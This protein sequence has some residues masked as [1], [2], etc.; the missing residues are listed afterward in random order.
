M[1]PLREWL[2]G[3]KVILNH[4]RRVSMLNLIVMPLPSAMLVS[5]TWKAYLATDVVL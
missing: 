1:P 4:L 2:A 5:I 3:V